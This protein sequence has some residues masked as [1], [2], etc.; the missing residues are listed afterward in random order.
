RSDF[1]R[2]RL[3]CPNPKRARIASSFVRMNAIV[4]LETLTANHENRGTQM[5][6]SNEIRRCIS[7]CILSVAIAAPAFSQQVFEGNHAVTP[8]F[9]GQTRAP[10]APKSTSFM[11]TEFVTGL[12]RPW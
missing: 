11:V 3:F 7:G 1:V 4:A 8:T 12:N 10:L 6:W 2:T 5:K 9:E